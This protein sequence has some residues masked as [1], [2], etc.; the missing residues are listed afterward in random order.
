[1]TLSLGWCLSRKRQWRVISDQALG[2]VIT[3][4]GPPQVWPQRRSGQAVS[5]HTA[6]VKV[7]EESL[8]SRCNHRC[9]GSGD[10]RQMSEYL[11]PHDSTVTPAS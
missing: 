1:M 6:K 3:D 10:V 5:S 8:S 9:V 11:I 4:G 2:E 7:T